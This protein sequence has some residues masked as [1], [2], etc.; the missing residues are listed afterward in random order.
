MGEWGN[1][2]IRESENH[3]M[4][5]AEG[6]N[7]S[8]AGSGV[9]LVEGRAF[10]VRRMAD[11][12]R[13]SRLRAPASERPLPSGTVRGLGRTVVFALW[14]HGCPTR[15][16]AHDSAP[17]VRRM[18]ER[19]RRRRLGRDTA[20]ASG[21]RVWSRSSA[22]SVLSDISDSATCGGAGETPAL[23]GGA[24]RDVGRICRLVAGVTGGC[25]AHHL[26]VRGARRYLEG[27]IA[28]WEGKVWQ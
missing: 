1:G 5:E 9:R 4:R 13:R 2:G 11:R 18:A 20:R 15:T 26:A 12:A 17:Y 3:R 28:R 14:S 19:A 7:G 10:Y 16:G 6:R 22:I 21:W 23:P 8:A 27:D 24:V 25:D